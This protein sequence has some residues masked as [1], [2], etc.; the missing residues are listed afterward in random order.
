[1]P[2]KISE[3]AMKARNR[4]PHSFKEKEIFGDG[5]Y[6]VLTCAFFHPSAG[7]MTYSEVHLFDT[8]EK[9]CQFKAELDTPEG[10]A[11]CHART[12]GLCTG[13]HLLVDLMT[14]QEESDQQPS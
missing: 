6:A 9:A 10:G 14:L 4:W 13:R 12:K 11:Y 2:K 1:M 8:K 3:W 5:Q 7:R